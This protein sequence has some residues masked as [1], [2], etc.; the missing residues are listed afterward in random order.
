MSTIAPKSLTRKT[1]FP[2]ASDVTDALEIRLDTPPP[3]FPGANFM[4]DARA[5][6]AGHASRFVEA[7]LRHAPGGF[8]D[9]VLGELLYRKST[10]FR[11]ATPATAPQSVSYDELLAALRSTLDVA[12]GA[13]MLLTGEMQ[14]PQR[15]GDLDRQILANAE[16]LLPAEDRS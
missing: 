5:W 3:E 2:V 4:E 10:V 6:Y 1:G 8:V 12:R 13:E 15:L 11:I 9:A 16:R 14:G 7:L